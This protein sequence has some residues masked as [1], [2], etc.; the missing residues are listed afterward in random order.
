MTDVAARPPSPLA[1]WFLAT[2][3]KTLV[4]GVVPVAVGSAIALREQVF[5]PLPALAALVGALLI[6]IGT[7]LVNDYFDFKRGAD[8]AERLGPPR[9]TAQGWLSPKAVFTGAMVC[10]GL[11]FVVGLYLVAVAGWPLVVIGLTSLAAGYAYTGGPFPLAYN[12]LGDLFVLV[13]FGFVAVGGT[14]FVLAH[15][16][17]VTALI[18]AVPVGL[19]GVALL[20]VNNTRDAKTD[21]AAGKRTL[22]VRFGT[23]FGKAEYVACLVVSALVPFALWLSGLT[24]A[25]VLLALLSAPLAVP[26]LKTLFTKT[27]V[28]L[29]EALAGTAKLQMIYGV[30]FALGLSR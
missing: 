13:F 29:N 21:E 28:A 24:T 20:A 17:S 18:A 15:A 30:L 8:T 27:G 26:P 6:Q 16:L 25:W 12:G 5:Q 10:F 9:A 2:R 1:A 22:V 14:Y 7:N 3:P 4:A 23:G 19:L 11:A